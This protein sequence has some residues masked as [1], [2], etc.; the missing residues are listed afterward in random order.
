MAQALFCLIRR[1]IRL[2]FV[3]NREIPK[4]TKKMLKIPESVPDVYPSVCYNGNIP[5]Q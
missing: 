5:N 3:Q 1:I 4:T 2:S